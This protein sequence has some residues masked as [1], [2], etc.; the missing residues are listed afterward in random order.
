MDMRET[1]QSIDRSAAAWAARLDG[2]PLG[3]EE[4]EALEVWLAA[5]VRRQGALV[6]AQALMI[7]SHA[8]P[9]AGS[10]TRLHLLPPPSRPPRRK[11]AGW[12]RLVAGLAASV[13][14]AAFVVLLVDAPQ[15]YATVKGESRTLPFADGAT[16]MLDTRTRIKVYDNGARI[17][18]L[19]G[20]VFVQTLPDRTERPLVVEVSGKRLL[21]TRAA[22]SVRRLDGMPD[23]VTV[24]TGEVSLLGAA[25]VPD[26]VVSSGQRLALP[27]RGRDVSQPSNLSA[28]EIERQLAWRSGYIAFHGDSL[29]DATRAFARYSDEQ[30]IVPDPS[31]ADRQVIGWYAANNPVGFARA[32]AQLLDAK[33]ER[34]DGRIVIRPED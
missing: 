19:E 29:A 31:L 10:P 18:L 3:P 11:S 9:A 1:G 26:A 17:R 13:L 2:A 20:E 25:D 16:V 24:Q 23:V 33:M 28:D 7:Q 22:F 30:V 32:T 12:S 8:Q 15:A 34:V 6:R 27:T 21:A 14:V 4:E 5:D